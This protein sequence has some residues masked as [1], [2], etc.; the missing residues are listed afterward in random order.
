MIM[1]KIEDRRDEEFDKAVKSGN[2]DE[3]EATYIK[4]EKIHE[5]KNRRY[6]M[7]SLNYTIGKTK[8]SEYGDFLPSSS[9]NPEEALL[10]KEKNQ[11]TTKIL[12]SLEFEVRTSF[13][14]Y[15]EL[16]Y[17]PGHE[18]FTNLVKILKTRGVEKSDK[19]VKKYVSIAREHLS[20]IYCP[21]DF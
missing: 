3:V 12:N 6:G 21:S 10:K 4:A 19:T 9:C 15:N 2:P 1:S 14:T 11:E 20:K 5:R 13:A 17:Y 7:R 18:N 16:G 8:K